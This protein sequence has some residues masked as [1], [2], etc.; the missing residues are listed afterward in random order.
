MALYQ[1]LVFPEGRTESLQPIQSLLLMYTEQVLAP[2]TLV[3]STEV[4]QPSEAGRG[5]HPPGTNLV[6]H[7]THHAAI[8]AYRQIRD[9][10][11]TMGW[12]LPKGDEDRF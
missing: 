8:S 2:V 11:L 1:Q 7:L 3:L 5:R 6:V 9:L 12:P 10:A 4:E